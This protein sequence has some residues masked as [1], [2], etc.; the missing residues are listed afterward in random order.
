MQMFGQVILVNLIYWQSLTTI[1]RDR[2]S[3]CKSMHNKERFSC[4]RPFP[5][6][7]PGLVCL[8]N[9]HEFPIFA[10]CTEKDIKTVPTGSRLCSTRIS[11]R[12]LL[13]RH[14]V[15]ERVRERDYTSKQ[16]VLQDIEARDY[17]HLVR[18]LSKMVTV[19]LNCTAA[20]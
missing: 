8:P 2:L 1:S 13:G 10:V 5:I 15:R 6:N 11:L 17:P 16:I 4:S 12:G 7:L 18:Y 19:Q 3:S 9:A 14:V 20:G